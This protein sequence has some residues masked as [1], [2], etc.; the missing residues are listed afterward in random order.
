MKKR[1]LA[2]TMGLVMVSGLLAGCGNGSGTETETGTN[3]EASSPAAETP[4]EDSSS[5]GG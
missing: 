5:G 2:L 4:A 3:P 1:L